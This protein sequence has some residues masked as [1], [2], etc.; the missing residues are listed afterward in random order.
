MIGFIL[1]AMFTLGTLQAA[2]PSPSTQSASVPESG[3]ELTVYLLTFEPGG[4]VWERFGHNALWIRD[5]RSGVDWAYDYGR[6]QFGQTISGV[7]RFAGRF[8]AAD[9]RYSMGDGDARSYLAGY[10]RA[11]RSIWS[12]ELDL[13]PAAR[14]ALRDFLVWNAKDE[15]KYYQYHYYLDNCSTRIRDALDRVLAG[16]L[17]AWAE[18]TTT[19]MTYRD[20]TRRTTENSP[21]TYTLLM[22]GLGQPVDR[23]LS[24]WEEMFLPI[25]LRPYLNQ[26]TV[27]DPDGRRHPLVRE[28][29]HLVESN[30]FSVQDRPSNW[31]LRYLVVGSVFGGILVGLGR[32]G[33]RSLGGR[34]G[35]GVVSVGWA[36]GSGLGGVVLVLLWALSDHRFSYWNENVLQLNLAAMAL[37]L[38]LP[39]AIWRGQA[40]YG[41]GVR[42]A[43]VMAAS[44]A[45]G[46][47]L[48]VLPQMGQNNLEM[49]ALILPAHLGVWL[50]LRALGPGPSA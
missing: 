16:Q 23:A 25:M 22:L 27:A 20:H 19:Q 1:A 26:L 35:F 48:K 21:T 40:R 8:A 41:Q 43:A 10:Q 49:I 46:L 31:T 38:V 6:F 28:E 33:R 47:I 9:L 37:A 12:Q 17:K 4:L 14:L 32:L 18:S 5:R 24:P 39:R 29:R 34:L 15:N 7:L 3:D 2:G 11:G 42:L 44:S 50:G 13:P 45:L 30:R 36:A